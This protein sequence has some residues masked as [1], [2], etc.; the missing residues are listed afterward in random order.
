MFFHLLRR[1]SLR[2]SLPENYDRPIVTM[3]EIVFAPAA[4][5]RLYFHA[6]RHLRAVGLD[7][8]EL[9]TYPDALVGGDP[10]P[11]VA[12]D[13]SVYTTCSMPGDRA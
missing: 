11:V 6:N 2:W 9:F 3:Q 5:S 12:P 1:A 4:Q 10:Q 8:T 7:G 13:G